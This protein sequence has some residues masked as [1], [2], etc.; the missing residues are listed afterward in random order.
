MTVHPGSRSQTDCPLT[1]R[2]QSSL[3]PKLARDFG[4]A[5]PVEKVCRMMDLLDEAAIRR[6]KGIV[7]DNAEALFSGP[8]QQGQPR[9]A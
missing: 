7:A 1:V 9:P 5:L 4:V 3:L 8:L 6:L 2:R